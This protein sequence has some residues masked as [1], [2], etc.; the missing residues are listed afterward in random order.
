MTLPA[1]RLPSPSRA[2]RIELPTLAV[3]AVIHA[4]WLVVTWWHAALPLPLVALLGGL[5][6]AWHGSLQ[7]ETIHGHPTGRRAIDGLIGSI[8]L[9]LWLPYAVYRRTHIAHHA[10]RRTTDPHADPES[11]YRAEAGG[12]RHRIA[13]L[14]A[15]LAARLVFGPLIR[16]SLFLIDELRR[17]W[18]EP[19]LFLRDW[20]P[21]LLGVAAVLWWLHYVDL[22]VPVY[23]AAF[24]YPGMM[25]SLLRSFAEHRADGDPSRRA[26][27]VRRPGL[28]G[29]LFLHNNLHAVHHARPDLSWYR[30]PAYFRANRLSF[31]QAPTYGSYL[32]ILRTYAWRAQDDVVHPDYRRHA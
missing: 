26:A 1:T 16:I 28:F 21:H 11:H 31:A 24:V 13:L 3:A 4:G 12:W 8:P 22:P 17:A 18:A 27:I 25:L 32:E 15:P 14:E 29:L 6:V 10:T 2:T 23:L 19:A 20:L 9:S 5:L 7:H 30:L